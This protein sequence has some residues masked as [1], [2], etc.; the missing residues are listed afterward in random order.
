[1]TRAAKSCARISHLV[2][3]NPVGIKVSDRETRDIVAAIEKSEVDG[4]CGLAWQTWKLTSPDWIANN[5]LNVLTQ[6]G[7]EKNAE[8]PDVPLAIDQMKNPDDKKVLELIVGLPD[9]RVLRVEVTESHI[10]IE[11]EST[12]T[13]GYSSPWNSLG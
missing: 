5:K 7:L 1:M 6:F 12:Q 13:I 3:A 9:A 8:I 4:V 2:L 10:K 11:L